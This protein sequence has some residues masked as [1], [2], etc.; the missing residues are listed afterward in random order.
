[1][2]IAAD[3]PR[4]VASV[5]AELWR[6]QV[7]PFPP[8]T[9]GSWMALA[10]DERGTLI[11]VYPLG[12]VLRETD[13][14][15]DAH[16]E[17]SGTDRFSPTHG[18]IATMLDQDMVLAIAAREGWPAK[19]RKRGNAFGVVELW[20]EGRQMMEVLTPEMQSEYLAFMGAARPVIH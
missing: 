17:A 14:D 11:E 5:I 7:R 19:Y 8:V 9:E 10:G 4:H 16:G 3:D 1:M 18:A 20:I 12:T 13:G 6:G 2:S 15:S